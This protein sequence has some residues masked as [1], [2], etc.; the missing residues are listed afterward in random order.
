MTRVSIY[1]QELEDNTDTKKKKWFLEACD[2]RKQINHLG[3][4][5]DTAFKACLVRVQNA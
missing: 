5:S 1:S 4:D 2:H 3:K